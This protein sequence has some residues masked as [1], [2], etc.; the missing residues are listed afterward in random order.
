M[1]VSRE[2][3]GVSGVTEALVAMATELNLEL[4][5]GMGFA[6]DEVESCGPNDLLIAI[7]AA[8]DEAL[9]TAQGIATAALAASAAAVDFAG[10]TAISRRV[11]TAPPD[12]TVALVSVPGANAFVEATAAL[13]R[14]L[15]VMVFS[16]NVPL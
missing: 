1:Q 10:S 5:D 6:A 13:R 4:L 8:D 16:N 3:L 15:H 11:E 12:A 9:L 2:V 7:A 14:G